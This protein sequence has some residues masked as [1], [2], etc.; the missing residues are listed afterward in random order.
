MEAREKIVALM[1]KYCSYR[2]LAKAISRHNKISY[3]MV[4]K[5]YHKKVEDISHENFIAIEKVYAQ[6]F[7]KHE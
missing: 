7:G 4:S 5:I 1:P 3:G 6:H 2:K